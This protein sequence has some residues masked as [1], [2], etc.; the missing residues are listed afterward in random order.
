M[1]SASNALK[2]TVAEKCKKMGPE[3]VF[4]ERVRRLFGANDEVRDSGLTEP[5][6]ENK[7]K[8]NFYGNG[9]YRFYCNC[10]Q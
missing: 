3:Y 9:L 7:R 2:N 8:D 4:A 1:Q 6:K 10:V 5:M